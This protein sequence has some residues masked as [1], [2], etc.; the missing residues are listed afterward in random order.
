MLCSPS[1]AKSVP[2]QLPGLLSAAMIGALYHTLRSDDP[3]A[4]FPILRAMSTET[5]SPASQR[6]RQCAAAV[7]A[8]AAA[9][10]APLVVFLAVLVLVPSL[11]P[12]LLLRPHHVVPYVASG[13]LRALAFDAAASAVTYNLSAVLR[14]DGPPN[15]YARRYTGIRAA[16]FY[17]GQE[18]GAA[19]AL[20]GFTQRSGGGNALPVAWA[21]V[22]RVPPGRRA[23][24]VAAAL[25]R[26]R[27]E[28]WISVKVAVRAAQDGAESDFACVL[29]FPVPHKRDGGGAGNGAAPGVFDGGS[30]IDAIRTEF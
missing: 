12:R 10:L 29:S 16:P 8:A 20:P 25:A 7:A 3:A 4:A 19:V 21:G 6:R 26:E 30:C 18:L 5:P 23:R 24:A 13:E 2:K 14:F 15:L 27:A 1:G 9:C 22:Q 28:E 17:A 11:I